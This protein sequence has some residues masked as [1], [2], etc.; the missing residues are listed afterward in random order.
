MAFGRLP[1]LL[2]RRDGSEAARRTT[3]RPQSAAV[4]GD[5]DPIRYER[6]RRALVSARCTWP[7]SDVR[8]ERAT[9]SSV[10][11]TSTRAAG[12]RADPTTR[13]EA[14]LPPP[15]DHPRIN[16]VAR[17]MWHERGEKKKNVDPTPE[18]PLSPPRRSR[19]RTVS[20]AIG[21]PPPPPLREK[22]Q[23]R[24]PSPIAA[25][26]SFRTEAETCS[27]FCGEID[28]E[29][30]IR[31]G[32][33]CRTIN[34]FV[35]AATAPRGRARECPSER[36]KEGPEIGGARW[37]ESVAECHRKGGRHS[38]G[39]LAGTRRRRLLTRGSRAVIATSRPQHAGHR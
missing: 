27:A 6:R 13:P 4:Q 9:S 2:R 5:V 32:R 35:R 34:V 39:G 14:L 25:G 21:S 17:D 8:R 30:Y 28:E 10:R 1:T 37:R 33:M 38:D 36:P 12:P 23:L 22:V 24:W 19:A 15:P 20:Q 18:H 16:H 11:G 3:R 26:A 29:N 31:S 7:R